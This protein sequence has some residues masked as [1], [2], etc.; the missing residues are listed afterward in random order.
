MSEK[1][2]PPSTPTEEPPSPS[3]FTAGGDEVEARR[4]RRS[5]RFCVAAVAVFCLGLAI[6]DNYGRYDKPERLYRMAL[7]L[8]D[9]SAR[10]I[11]RNAVSADK[12]RQE[13]QSPKYVEALA[14]I[15]EEDLV[16]SRYAEA[17]RLNPENQS[18]AINYGCRLFIKGQYKEAREHFRE[19]GLRPPKNILPRYLEAAAAAEASSEP[20]SLDEAM[21][22][23]ARTNNS[24]DA[25]VFPKP[26]WH[27]SFP[28][29]G[30]WYAGLRRKLVD[31]ACA[32]IYQLKALLVR[33]ARA[34]I[35][36]GRVQDWDP[37]LASLQTLGERLLTAAMTP[38]SNAG[39]PAAVTGI[40]CQLDAIELRKRIAQML[41]GAP[42]SA[43]IERQVKL[44]SA[45]V[46]LQNFEQG[47]DK[48]I[49]ADREIYVVP[50]RLCGRSF[51]W[52]S[53]LYGLSWL[54]TRMTDKRRRNWSTPHPLSGKTLISAGTLFFLAALTALSFVQQ[55][56][57][58]RPL[59]LGAVSLSWNLVLGLLLLAGFFYPRLCVAQV[60]DSSKTYWAA[61]AAMMR[62]YYGLLLGAFICVVCVWVLGYASLRGLYPMQLKLLITGLGAEEL[63]TL[64]QVGDMLR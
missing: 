64:R 61:Y 57:P 13:T 34:D 53:A 58:V 12:A 38:E 1:A 56:E 33:G 4:A 50:W 29:K 14:S 24:S 49:D 48:R 25:L 22:L 45:L 54:L 9:P 46:P 6:W 44:T 20:S 52:L 37:R 59:L 10:A 17:Y 40:Q 35:D 19:A 47:R 30:M 3:S 27:A 7:T 11:L 31:Q 36:A 2:N 60:S 43:L 42:D 55:I 63:D 8:E 62:R 5:F 26:L 21:T 41:R 28:T 16:L 39:I 18:L 51:F 23:I 15:E 32:P